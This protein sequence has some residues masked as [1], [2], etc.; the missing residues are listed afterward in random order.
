[1]LLI[2]SETTIGE[3]FNIGGETEISIFELAKM[4]IELTNSKS[5]IH[6]VPYEEAYK[7]GYE[8]IYRRVPDISKINLHTGWKPT[9]SIEDTIRDVSNYFSKEIS[10]NH[11]FLDQTTNL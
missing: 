9:K 3:V 10:A 6:F 4:T 5:L 2:Q 11:G 7:I 1:M 8:D